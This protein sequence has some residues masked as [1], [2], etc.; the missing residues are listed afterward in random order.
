MGRNT[1]TGTDRGGRRRTRA[2]GFTMIELLVVVSLVIILASIGMAQYKN[3]VVR[4]QEAVLKEDLFRMR[5]VIDQYYRGQ[6]A[7]SADAR[8]TRHGRISS[9]DPEG[10]VYGVRGDVADRRGRARPGQPGRPSSASTTSG[11]GRKKRPS[12]AA[13]TRSGNGSLAA[14]TRRC[15]RGR[16]W[17][18]AAA[19]GARGLP[20]G[21]SRD[22]LRQDAPGGAHRFDHH[23]VRQQHDRWPQRID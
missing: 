13:S 9:R 23:A 4:A 8:R 18:F 22:V 3:G 15:T 12:T 11:A 1:V 5:D 16:S 20:G 14:M 21:S 17:P 6:A 2:G 19:A 10:P 7:A